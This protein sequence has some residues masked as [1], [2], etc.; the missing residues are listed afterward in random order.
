MPNEGEERV[1]R[2]KGVQK[3]KEKMVE[4]RAQESSKVGKRYRCGGRC[5]VQVWREVEM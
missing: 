5:K 1:E 2:W 3:S 4:C